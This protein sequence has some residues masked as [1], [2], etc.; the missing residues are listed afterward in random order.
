VEPSAPDPSDVVPLPLEPPACVVAEFWEKPPLATPF[1]STLLFVAGKPCGVLWLKAP[2]YNNNSGDT[3]KFVF[4]T[5]PLPCVPPISTCLWL[6]A[7]AI[8]PGTR[9][10]V[11]KLQSQELARGHA[12]PSQPFLIP[13]LPRPPIGTARGQLMWPSTV[14]VALS[15]YYCWSSVC[16]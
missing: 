9:N 16:A 12:M 14:L 11:S 15:T 7:C 1:N 6:L 10:D 4:H 13:L 2:S 5:V 8:P 3:S